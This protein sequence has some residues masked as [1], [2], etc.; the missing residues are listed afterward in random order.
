MLTYAS[1]HFQWSFIARGTLRG[2]DQQ[3]HIK[4]R[5]IIEDFDISLQNGQMETMLYISLKSLEMP[6][7]PAPKRRS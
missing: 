3:E 2:L 6:W 5:E 4:E 1:T 7:H